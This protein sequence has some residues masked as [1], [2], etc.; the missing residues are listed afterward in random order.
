[1]LTEMR[2]ELLVAGTTLLIWSV[3]LVR[4][5]KVL[6][7]SEDNKKELGKTFTFI[8]IV[9]MVAGGMLGISASGRGVLM[10]L[11]AS[12]GLATMLAGFGVLIEGL[13]LQEKLLQKIR[14]GLGRGLILAV[15]AGAICIGLSLWRFVTPG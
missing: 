4:T 13:I 14:W 1:M 10:G 11:Q 12:F 3:S 6:K 15:I 9:L 7:T 8:G 2:E 5:W